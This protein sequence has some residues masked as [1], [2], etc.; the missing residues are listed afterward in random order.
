MSDTISANHAKDA[1]LTKVIGD[2]Q[3]TIRRH[4]PIQDPLR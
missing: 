2:Y 1:A 4:R 3:E